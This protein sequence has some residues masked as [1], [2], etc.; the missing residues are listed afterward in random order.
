MLINKQLMNTI[1]DFMTHELTQAAAIVTAFALYRGI[2][3]RTSLNLSKEVKNHNDCSPIIISAF[4]D[5]ATLV[6]TFGIGFMFGT[7]EG[8]FVAGIKALMKSYYPK[9]LVFGLALHC[10]VVPVYFLNLLR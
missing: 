5:T 9:T 4:I 6:G 7:I 1:T 8:G 2:Q 3:M 10:F